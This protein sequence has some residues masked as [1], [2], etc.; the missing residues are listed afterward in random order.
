MKAGDGA[1]R[2]LGTQEVKVFETGVSA[3]R[4]VSLSGLLI[5]HHQNNHTLRKNIFITKDFSHNALITMLYLSFTPQGHQ[6]TAFRECHLQSEGTSCAK[7][8][9]CD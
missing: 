3:P 1:G 9:Y 8:N 2:L 5:P 7:I 6:E 4:G